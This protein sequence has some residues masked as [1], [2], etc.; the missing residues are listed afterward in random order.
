MEFLNYLKDHGIEVFLK[1][2]DKLEVKTEEAQI[3]ESLLQQIRIR[4]KDLISHLQNSGK[5]GGGGIV[6]GI[7]DVYALSAIQEGILFHSILSQYTGMYIEQICCEMTGEFDV[8]TFKQSLSKLVPLHSILRT[9]FVHESISK[10]VQRV[11]AEVEIPVDTYGFSYNDGDELKDALNEF[12][13]KDRNKGF[14]LA[15]PPLIRISLIKFAPDSYYLV[16]TSHHILMDGWSMMLLLEKAFRYYR[17]LIQNIEPKKEELDDYKDFINYLQSQETSAAKEFWTHNLARFEEASEFAFKKKKLYSVPTSQS[18]FHF[19]LDK[20]TSSQLVDEA[21]LRGVTVNNVIQAVWSIVLSRYTNQSEVSFGITL[22][23][24]PDNIKNI[25][26]RIGLYINTLPFCVSINPEISFWDLAAYLNN[27]QLKLFEYQFTP[28]ADIQDWVGK[29]P[30]FNNILVFENYPVQSLNENEQLFRINDINVFEKTNYDIS[31]IV[32]YSDTL[33]FEVQFDES[34]YDNQQM[35]WLEGHIKTLITQAISYPNRR[36]KQM[37]IISIEERNALFSNFH[38]N[39]NLAVPDDCL[40]QLFEK[41]VETHPNRKAL[42]FEGKSYSYLELNN[43]SNILAH[44]LREQGVGR[45]ILVGLSIER[46]AEMVI[47]IFAILKAGGAYVPVDVKLPEE[48]ISYMLENSGVKLVLT[49]ASTDKL[50]LICGENVKLLDLRSFNFNSDAYQRGPQNINTPNDAIYALYTSGSTGKP[51]G[52]VLEHRNITNLVRHCIDRTSLDFTRVL[53]YSTISFDVS[54]SEI[55]YTLCAGGEIFIITEEI[56]NNLDLLFKFIDVHKICTVFFPMS[57]LRI[58][59]SDAHLKELIPSCIKHIQ[60]AGEQ[61]VINN[62][63]KTYLKEKNIFLHNHYGPSETHVS[64]T[65]EIHPT[66]NIPELPSIGRPIQNCWNYIVDGNGLL[67][68]VGVPGELWIGGVPVGREYIK[69]DDLNQHKFVTDPFHLEHRLYKTGDL[70]RWLPDGNI[71]FLGR[72][73]R[74]VKIRGFRVE[75]GEIEQCLLNHSQVKQAVVGFFTDV[76]GNKEI[77]VYFVS[78]ETLDT[79]LLRKYL[80]KHLPDYMIPSVFVQVQDIPITSNGK[81]NLSALPEAGSKSVQGYVP[82]ANYSEET[83]VSICKEI[84]NSNGSDISMNDNFLA[85]GGHSI[86]AMQLISRIQK[87][88]SVKLKLSDVFENPVLADLAEVITKAKS[89]PVNT[90]KKADYKAYYKT[91]S[92]QRRLFFLQR[93]NPSITTYNMPVAYI[94]GGSIDLKRIENAFKRLIQR[95]E[96]LRTSFEVVNNEVVQRIESIINFKLDVEPGIEAECGDYLKR[97][98]RPFDLTL[99]PLFRIKLIKFQEDKNLLMLDFHHIISDA[100][101]IDTLIKDFGSLYK[102]Q[103]L[104]DLKLQYKD[105]AEWQYSTT[106]TAI[107][108]KQAEFWLEKLSSEIPRLKLPVSGQNTGDG[109]YNFIIGSKKTQQMRQYAER[110]EVTMNILLQTLFNVL[111]SKVSYQETICIGTPMSGRRSEEL[112]NVVGMFVN[113]VVLLNYAEADKLFSNFLQEVKYTAIEAFENQEYP[114]D[115]LVEQLRDRDIGTQPLFNIMFE[116]QNVEVGEIS[117]P[118]LTLTQKLFESRESKFDLTFVV[119]ETAEGIHLEYRY[120]GNYFTE[121]SITDFN[122]NLQ[123]IIDQVLRNDNVT[124]EELTFAGHQTN[125]ALMQLAKPISE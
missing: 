17:M 116:F 21:R 104:T 13:I 79:D 62:N 43:R 111:L 51:K 98:I 77:R 41:Q 78:N 61:V 84:L 120:S 70:A 4:K 26:N 85:I 97:F 109:T 58:L 3:D 105:Y 11:H 28:L 64:S 49:G 6:K 18:A 115:E 53:Q 93:F 69:R 47:A 106:F 118:G 44:V 102:V 22:A 33:D 96:G 112:E 91:S 57:L 71:E 5:K 9:S 14:D 117:I 107:R 123:H 108:E 87:K 12:L 94:V 86:K 83:L 27:Q 55:F 75:P 10:P 60:T 56:R 122:L 20:N 89:N 92:M 29:K 16:W 100:F 124:I 121:N 66:S 119:Q 63:F 90:I 31:L 23:N 40:H 15:K 95:H 103:P 37:E 38:E 52:V 68:P 2:N 72:M 114:Y 113:T 8:E 67:Q 32:K 48:R 80:Q 59:F 65:L 36:V 82:P 88:M 1:D 42:Y 101:S 110:Q 24:R 30:L 73:D 50:H 7:D 76:D 125:N 81:I 54:V 19:S 25:E 45:N 99:S 46:S 74:Q 39:N 34:N 35:S